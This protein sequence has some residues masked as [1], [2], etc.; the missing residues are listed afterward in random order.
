MYIWNV[1]CELGSR[2]HYYYVISK[3]YIFFFKLHTLKLFSVL[4][5]LQNHGSCFGWPIESKASNIFVQ[6][7]VDGAQRNCHAVFTTFFFFQYK[8]TYLWHKW[9]FPYL[10]K[11][12]HT[13]QTKTLRLCS[14]Y[15]VPASAEAV[16]THNT[17]SSG[18]S[19]LLSKT[20]QMTK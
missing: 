16:A 4:V 19:N 3:I 6:I 13:P 12:N 18:R 9:I 1:D 14:I 10:I 2:F 8:M 17:V 7:I 5:N 20:C 15:E 11:S